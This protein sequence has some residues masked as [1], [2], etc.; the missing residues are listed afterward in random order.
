MNDELSIEAELAA[1]SILLA[2]S[3]EPV[4]AVDDDDYFAPALPPHSMAA[5]EP[6]VVY[7]DSEEDDD[8][9]ALIDISPS[10]APETEI[11]P[12][13]DAATVMNITPFVR[14]DRAS[15]FADRIAED[16]ARSL[17]GEDFQPITD[18]MK[19]APKKVA[20]KV[21]NTLIHIAGRGKLSSYTRSAIAL[22]KEDP[23]VSNAKLIARY[24]A[25]GYT[26]GTARSQASQQMSVLPILQV[27]RKEG[28]VLMINNDS[29]VL[30]LLDQVMIEQAPTPEVIEFKA[31]PRPEP[32]AEFEDDDDALLA[33]I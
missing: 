25:E 33:S 4:D 7:D 31:S 16:R 3:D 20:D 2:G 11:D 28:G 5:R 17:L 8:I 14:K 1:V 29:R 18:G 23:Q 27:A 13:A 30:S 32:V 19:A 15:A 22:L 12:D 21:Y 24:E 26:G 9:V 6:V 10:P